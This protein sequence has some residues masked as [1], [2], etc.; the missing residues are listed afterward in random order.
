MNTWESE[1]TATFTIRVYAFSRVLCS[2][3]KVINMITP[4]YWCCIWFC[5]FMIYL[6]SFWHSV[7]PS[8]GCFLWRTKVYDYLYECNEGP[9]WTYSSV[10]YSYITLYNVMAG[11]SIFFLSKW[12]TL[13]I[14]LI[15]PIE[16]KEINRSIREQLFNY[17]L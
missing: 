14:I 13:D 1:G 15:K 6:Q 11:I 9:V 16:E 7:S 2:R 8:I 4:S 17:E 12:K 10:L 3:N 5:N